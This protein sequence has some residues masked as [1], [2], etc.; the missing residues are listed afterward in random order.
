MKQKDIYLNYDKEIIDY[1]NINKI[2]S[3]M[4]NKYFDS[5]QKINPKVIL[6]KQNIENNLFKVCKKFSN[7]HDQ[8]FS[9]EQILELLDGDLI[10][11]DI[12]YQYLGKNTEINDLINNFNYKHIKFQNSK[13]YF[14]KNITYKFDKTNNEFNIYQSEPGSRAFFIKGDLKDININFYGD[15]NETV[16]LDKLKN[17]PININGLTA[18]LSFVNLNFDNI[19]I[20]SN[21]ST[22]EDSINFIKTSG[23][24]KE[25]DIRDSLKDGLDIDF[26][27]INVNSIT[28]ETS[29][30]DC[31]DLS[32][33][34]YQLDHLYLSNC[35][36]KGLSAG[37]KSNIK[38]NDIIV[39]Q[40]KTG[41]A[42]K[43][44][45]IVTANKLSL[46]KTT[47]CLDIYRKKQ[48]FSGGILN[49]NNLNC[50]TGTIDIQAGSFTNH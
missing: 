13:F 39:N 45:S 24:V 25:I 8:S 3:T 32:F 5:I 23:T 29:G 36:D 48:E 44:S 31:V 11:N 46:K 47:K 49:L 35:G 43:D 7:C 21:N 37:E 19:K 12:E 30:N 1:N 14:N 9:D 41:I 40:A 2:D 27:K 33:G 50:E 28:V 42:V 16:M 18:C 38:L 10:I 22:C 6:V 4:W 34:D 17:Y 26:S 20:R 15:K